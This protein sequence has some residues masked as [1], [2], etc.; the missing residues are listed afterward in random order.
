MLCVGYM[1][2]ERKIQIADVQS[3][4]MCWQILIARIEFEFSG[5][6]YSGWNDIF[7]GLR[8]TL[9]FIHIF[10][11]ILLHIRILL[12]HIKIYSRQVDFLFSLVAHYYCV[13]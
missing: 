13:F 6:I 10:S 9:L 7:H 11:I 5:N 4:R 12:V 8:K 1:F 3:V 2:Y